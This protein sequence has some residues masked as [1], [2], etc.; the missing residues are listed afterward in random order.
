[1]DLR[2][3]KDLATKYHSKS[4]IIRVLTESWVEEN[5]YCPRCGNSKL[6][7]SPNNS[8]VSD[9]FCPNCKNEYELK[10]KNGKIGHKIPD[11]AYSTFIQR[12]TSNNNPDFFI[13]NY[14]A[15]EL[16]VKNFCI[17]PKYFFTPS[18]VEKRKPLSPTSR[19]AG[20][21]GC[22]ILFDEIPKQGQIY[23]ICKE[24]IIDKNTVLAQ[25][26]NSSLLETNFVEARGWLLDILN[27]VNKIQKQIFT[28]EDMYEFEEYLSIKY[29]LNHNIRPKIRQQLQ[30]LRN[31]GFLQFIDLGV[32]KK[33]SPFL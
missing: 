4:Q 17:I 8:K 29:P 18:I 12:I 19:R 2:F 15:K 33:R 6:L 24:T 32:Y 1:M 9:F 22:N 10:S 16:C 28:L 7:H 25:M 11:G 30:I 26:Q 20:W 14:D 3:N 13:L 23:I 31:K 5:M 27:C 21:V